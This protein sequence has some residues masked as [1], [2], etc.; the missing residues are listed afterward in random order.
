MRKEFDYLYLEKS[1]VVNGVEHFE[2]IKIRV[3]NNDRWEAEL[4]ARRFAKDNKLGRIAG[5]CFNSECLPY[6]FK[7]HYKVWECPEDY[8]PA[9]ENK[10]DKFIAN[11]IE[12]ETNAE[13]VI[14]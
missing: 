1:K 11:L 9:K 5:G 6:D 12:A 8:K 14:L 13:F 4:K 3:F 2:V 10:H 7:E